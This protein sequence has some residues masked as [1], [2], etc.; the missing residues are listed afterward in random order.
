LAAV[1]VDIAALT[2]SRAGAR[3]VVRAD[4]EVRVTA[5]QDG[6]VHRVVAKVAAAGQT[7]R[8]IL[9]RLPFTLRARG[10]VAKI[11]QAAEVLAVVVHLASFT[12][13]AGLAGAIDTDPRSAVIER[14]APTLPILQVVAPGR[15]LI[16][17]RDRVDAIVRLLELVRHTA[18]TD[19]LRIE[20][21]HRI[22][23]QRAIRGREALAVCA[24]DRIARALV[25]LR[26]AVAV[27]AGR[28]HSALAQSF[29]ALAIIVAAVPERVAGAVLVA[30]RVGAPRETAVRVSALVVLDRVGAAAREA[31]RVDTAGRVGHLRRRATDLAIANPRDALRR[32]GARAALDNLAPMR[33]AL[34]RTTEPAVAVK[35][36]VASSQGAGEV[37]CT[38]RLAD[39]TAAIV[40]LETGSAGLLATAAEDAGLAAKGK[41]GDA[42]L[43]VALRVVGT[44]GADVLASTGS[45]DGR[46]GFEVVAGQW[47]GGDRRGEQDGL[48]EECHEGELTTGAVDTGEHC[49]LGP[50]DSVE[51]A[52]RESWGKETGREEK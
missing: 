10:R 20:I 22:G 25:L 4:E 51:R 29:V 30:R 3:S 35:V 32:L 5:S 39:P 49:P 34:R 38:I 2:K 6:S 17:E 33:D 16:L 23:G 9:A 47:R 8:R 31:F 43:R 42:A 18:P 36:G 19:A 50:V 26:T 1:I 45:G 21:A 37:A 44:A 48:G 11:V 46:E 52:E 28:A 12:V 13:L 15:V 14:R 24:A 40:L 7:L 27:L 41:V